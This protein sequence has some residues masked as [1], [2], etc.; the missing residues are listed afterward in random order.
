MRCV[1]CDDVVPSRR[2]LCDLCEKEI[3]FLT[4]KEKCCERCGKKKIDCICRY[5]VFSFSGCVAAMTYDENSKK[6]IHELKYKPKSPISDYLASVMVKAL[7]EKNGDMTFDY[8][9]EVP[10]KSEEITKRGHNQSQTLARAISTLSNI[11]YL[12]SPII[13]ATICKYST[14]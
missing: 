10:M 14:N 1:V 9:T 13:Q 4:V 11:P 6:I 2:V 7:R 8:V 5:A 12:E 3:E